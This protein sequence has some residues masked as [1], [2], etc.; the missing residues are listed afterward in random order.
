MATVWRRRMVLA[1]LLAALVCWPLALEAAPSSSHNVAGGHPDYRD[2]VFRGERL[3]QELSLTTGVAVSP[4]LGMTVLSAWQWF[5][6]AESDRLGLPWHASPKFWGPLAAI[7][8]LL[9][10]KDCSKVAVPKILLVPLDALETL[11][12]KNI[13]GLLALPFLLSLVWHGEFSQMVL[14]AKAVGEW[15]LPPAQASNSAMAPAGFAAVA[16]V[17]TSLTVLVIHGLV[18]VCAQAGNM[19]ILL[20]PSSLLDTLLTLAKQILVALLLGLSHTLAGLL[21]ALLVVFL[22]CRFFPRAL[23]LVFFGTQLS[24]DLIVVRLL[25][26]AEAGPVTDRGIAC[27]TGIRL[28]GLPP[29]TPGWLRSRDGSLEFCFRPWWILAQRTVSTGLRSTDC[30][31]IEGVLMPSLVRR[32]RQRGLPLFCF[33]VAQAGQGP[34]LAQ[35]LGVEW[36]GREKWAGR[37][38]DGLRWWG[39]M[40]AARESGQTRGD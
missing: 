5:A 20:S 17:I 13:S 30:V 10:V 2:L 8:A 23:R 6:A 32:A 22:A 1:M 9:C 24:R 14:L 37:L 26:M 28:A 40:V 16:A 21:L 7:L 25:H 29:F 27:C 11:L 3:A 36:A 15:L 38:L 39:A 31:L 19:L 35:L 4:L 34:R 18:W 33:R 12:E